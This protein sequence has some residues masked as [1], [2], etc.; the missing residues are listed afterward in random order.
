MSLSALL[1]KGTLHRHQPSKNELAGLL[2][3]ADR[4]LADAGIKALSPEP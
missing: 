3:L 2:A 1:E 4:N